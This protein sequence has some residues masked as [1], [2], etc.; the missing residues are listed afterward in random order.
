MSENKANITITAKDEASQVFGKLGTAL[1]AFIAIDVFKH[2]IESGREAEN[3]LRQM[4]AVLASTGNSAGLAKDELTSL[5][6]SISKVTGIEDDAIIRGEN[7]LLT[8]TK[9]KGDIFKEATQAMV[10][11]DSA[12]T[13]GNSTAESLKGTAIKLGRALQD[14][15]KGMTALSRSGVAFT[16]VQKEQ[17]KALMDAGKQIEAQKIILG[18]LKKEFTGSAEAYSD[19]WKRLGTTFAELQESLGKK[20]LPLVAQIEPLM[21]DVAGALG[22]VA[23]SD[24]TKDI[25]FGV[26]LLIVVFQQLILNV[27][28]FGLSFET[29]VIGVQ[30]SWLK[31]AEVV[32]IG[33]NKVRQILGKSHEDTATIKERYAKQNQELHIK[34]LKMEIDDANK[35]RAITEQ[36]LALTKEYEKLKTKTKETGVS[37]R[38]LLIASE[39]EAEELSEKRKKE[40]AEEAKKRS[41]QE[42]KNFEASVQAKK[43]LQDINIKDEIAMYEQFLAT[44]KLYKD[45]DNN[46]EQDFINKI[47]AL[48]EKARTESG[49]KIIDQFNYELKLRKSQGTMTLAQEKQFINQFIATNKNYANLT[50][51]QKKILADQLLDIQLKSNEKQLKAQEDAYETGLN[52]ATDFKG[53][54]NKQVNKIFTSADGIMKPVTQGM[55]GMFG[56]LGGSMLG[57]ALGGLAIQGITSIFN[58]LFGGAGKTV[59]QVAEEQFD[60]M[61]DNTNRALEGIG[62]EKTIAEKQ[63]AVLKELKGQGVTSIDDQAL[64]NQL[65]VKVGTTINDA[66]G[67]K[68]DNIAGLNNQSLQTQRQQIEEAKKTVANIDKFMGMRESYL[69]LLSIVSQQQ[70]GDEAPDTPERRA[71][72]AMQKEMQQLTGVQNL[73]AINEIL[74]RKEAAKKYIN[75]QERLVGVTGTTTLDQTLENL[76]V[77]AEA[78]QIRGYAT[79]GSF[80]V[81]SPTAIINKDGIRMAGESGRETVS[82]SPQGGGQPIIIQLTLD[83]RVIGETVIDYNKLKAQGV[84]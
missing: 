59:A 10:D 16:E 62:R 21:M 38:T 74:G 25:V 3:N 1:K 70:T 12:M 57:G 5:A 76:R 55:Q 58:G 69:N 53:E 24:F 13:G 71:L 48:K 8:F 26:R 75:E 37:A 41:E 54:L 14:P 63:I 60:K 82:I 42:V 34:Q 9:I 39:D 77:K 45:K 40:L 49:K 19:P 30:Q 84:V 79:G 6:E 15:E 11:L 64:A 28:R 31:V 67:Q 29:M 20:L 22:K 52:L 23:E 43:A 18:E 32:E 78:K 2:L 50:L 73:S 7:M 66:I 65:G 4:D 44:H 72:F 47:N 56:M 83:S 80:D 17:V 33:T 68:L 61:I 81:T 51:D 46:V 36:S 27:Q 35:Q